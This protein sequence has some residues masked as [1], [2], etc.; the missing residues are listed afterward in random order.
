MFLY[1]LMLPYLVLAT[2]CNLNYLAILIRIFGNLY[3]LFTHS[4][5]IIVAES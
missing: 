4:L 3:K 2:I 1:T 5:Y